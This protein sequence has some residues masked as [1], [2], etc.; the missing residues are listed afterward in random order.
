MNTSK[1]PAPIRDIMPDGFTRLIAAK[2]KELV[3][4]APDFPRISDIVSQEKSTSKYWVAVEAVAMTVDSKAYQKRMA[5]LSKKHPQ[6][7]AA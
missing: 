5:Y 1:A 6:L 4:K 2:A 3:G 7:T